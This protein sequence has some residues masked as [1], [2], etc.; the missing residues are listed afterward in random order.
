M[1][2]IGELV[3]RI[4]AD[5]A[6]LERELKKAG[7]LTESTA[8]RM[9]G[10]LRDLRGQFADLLPALSIG[11]L[12]AFGRSAFQSADRI[13]DLSQRTG[14]LG[15]TLSALNVPLKQSGSSLDEFAGSLVRMN[16]AIADADQSKESLKAFD[17]LGLSIRKLEQ[18]SPEDQFYAIADALSRVGSQSEFTS[19]GM[20]IFGRSFATLAPLIRESKGNLAEFVDE[21]KR[22]GEALTDDELK[23]IDELGDRW[24]ATLEN[25]KH[26][27][28]EVVPLLEGL[29][30]VP[31]YVRAAFVEIPFMA[32]QAIGNKISGRNPAFEQAWADMQA[33]KN[34]YGPFEQYGP[35]M[36]QGKSAKGGN[37]GLIKD[38]KLDNAR[39]QLEDYNRELQRQ[40]ELLK[41]T[42]REQAAMKAGYD[43]LDL[44]Q[45][46]GVKNAAELVRVNQEL[47]RSNYDIA[48]AQQ[49]A[50]RFSQEM[51]DKFSD[52][53]AD[54]ALNFD[55]A[56]DA[57]TRFADTIAKM[58]L[59]KK[60]TGPLVDSLLGTS[61]GGGGLLGSLF[62]GGQMAA[63]SA[64]FIGPMPSS[65]FG[66]FFSG[67][68]F[69]GGGRPPVGK[70]SWV[71]EEGPELWVPDT[72]GTVVPNKAMGGGVNVYQT[73]N[74][75][76]GLPE[77]VGAAIRQAA[78]VIAAQAKAEVFAAMQRGG[79]ESRIAGKRT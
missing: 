54:I 35:H 9:T 10:A 37:A 16:N 76:P 65:G 75:Q 77:T 24:V 1:A 29:S 19:I 30:N 53:L 56:T 14:I 15:S 64:S 20:A 48:E 23:R 78:P 8:K 79:A 46:A 66:S 28:L 3:V 5:A 11:A 51:K 2:D 39:K 13:N 59:E 44:A 41:L 21:Q 58:I 31:D 67:L 45:K 57:A 55:N 74:M 27:L 36:Q 73:F 22:M 17:D 4:K 12:L 32:G 33:A 70:A 6:Q 63:P 18:L 71:G 26:K 52:S 60:V 7:A 40:S 50:I 69:A 25:M 68:G 72:A 38:T 61:S 42:P 34:Q 62:S 49:E 47:A 43:T